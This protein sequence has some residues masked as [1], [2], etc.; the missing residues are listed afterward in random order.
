MRLKL[1]LAGYRTFTTTCHVAGSGQHPVIFSARVNIR[2]LPSVQASVEV[3]PGGT[4]DM[5]L[6][7]S[8]ESDRGALTLST[9][10]APGA[11]SNAFAWARWI[12]PT[13]A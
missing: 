5:K 1:C 13:L 3:P 6:A 7:L 2:G 8:F 4:Q 12:R 10:M 9:E 11:A